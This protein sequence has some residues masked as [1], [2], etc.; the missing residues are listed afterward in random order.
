MMS[1]TSHRLTP[2]G[3]AHL[4]GVMAVQARAYGPALLE[5][6]EVLG[7]KLRAPGG[8]CW[9]AWA[10]GQGAAPPVLCAYAIA[11]ALPPGQ[12]LALNKPL[13]LGAAPAPGDW[14]YVHDIAVDPACAG[15]GLAARLLAQVLAAG[16]SLGLR[17]AMLVA[18]QGAQA[19][20]ARHGFA[21]GTP[22]MPVQGFGQG[23]VW[24]ARGL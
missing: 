11:H 13:G 22:P 5:L 19:Y 3:P 1:C 20:W 15:G 14:L 2:I 6:P 10:A 8:M 4:P 16:R 23:A 21:P 17:Q 18:V 7:S 9:G 24:M 12:A